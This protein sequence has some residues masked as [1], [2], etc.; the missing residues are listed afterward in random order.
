MKI[1]DLK[2]TPI[3]SSY[4][5]VADADELELYKKHAVSA[6]RKGVKIPG[7][8][9]GKAP[10]EMVEKFVDQE[11]LQNDFL[12]KAINELY[13]QSVDEQN[14]KVVNEPKIEIT[15]FVPF[16]TL[17]FSVLVDVITKVDL[18]DYKNLKLKLEPMP[19]T[20]EQSD[21]TLQELRLRT[22]K[23]K[24]VDRAAKLED[25]VEIDFE[26]KDFKTKQKLSQASGLDYKIILGS[27]SFIPG[28][29]EQLV[30]LK[31]GASKTFDI[32]FP[33][34]YHEV[35]FKGRKLSFKVDVKMVTEVELPKL[36]DVFA[37]SMGPFKKIDEF[38]TELKRQL[39]EENDRQS[40]RR[41]EDQILNTIAEKTEVE[42]PDSLKQSEITKLEAEAKQNA[43]YRGQSWSEF[44]ETLDLDE[45][46]Y[47]K[48]LDPI[49]VLR[50]KGGLAIGEIATKEKIEISASE[51][52]TRIAQLG[53]QYTDP[54][55]REELKDPNNRREILMRLLTE[56]VLD[57]LKTQI[58][59]S[60]K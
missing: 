45:E 37:A 25:Q 28:F 39:K 41:F 30:G 40:Q 5:I 54:Q 23:F 32:T 47:R 31:A 53:D 3:T 49:A 34:D 7:F 10:D 11:K 4:T 42:I 50:I 13:L 17:Q 26:G 24:E 52:D 27:N 12:N 55:M 43:L 15:K 2:S 59:K 60:S 1:D 58:K 33:K 38:K 29:E 46:G 48:Q 44:L 35:S 56:K 57:F 18:P 8:R 9:P 22:A 21:R 51:L 19:V 14:L 36:D 20:K 6:N 16:T